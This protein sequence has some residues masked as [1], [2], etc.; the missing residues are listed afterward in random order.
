MHHRW[1]KLRCLWPWLDT[2]LLLLPKTSR[3]SLLCMWEISQWA[4]K[5]TSIMNG[6]LHAEHDITFRFY[7]LWHVA[8]KEQIINLKLYTLITIW[9]NCSRMLH[10][11]KSSDNF[12]I[13]Y[14]KMCLFDIEWE[15]YRYRMTIHGNRY[16]GQSYKLVVGLCGATWQLQPNL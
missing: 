3:D 11:F 12:L 4:I 6:L 1:E 7:T 9:K 10:F 2:T 16:A 13:K 14:S 8:D 15:W 5:G